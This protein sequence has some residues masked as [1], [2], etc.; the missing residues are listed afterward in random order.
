VFIM[1][2]SIPVSQ[3]A[4]NKRF[5]MLKEVDALG[6]SMLRLQKNKIHAHSEPHFVRGD[7]MTIVTKSIFLRGHPNM[8]LHDRQLGPLS[9]EEQIWKQSYKLKLPTIV[10]SL[11]LFHVNNSRPCSTTS[12]RHGVLVIVP[13][14][15]EEFD[16]SH[17]CC[18]HQVFT[19]T[20]RQTLVLHDALL[21]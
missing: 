2:P 5:K 21:R 6:R 4:S 17:I 1:R 14:G 13:E 3:Y 16:F 9:I 12:L 8:N 20:P 15:D 11:S 19:R 7:K 10:R 18:V